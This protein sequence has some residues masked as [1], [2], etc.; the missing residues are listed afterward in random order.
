MSRRAVGTT[1]HQVAE[2]HVPSA[3]VVVGIDHGAATRDEARLEARDPARHR[4]AARGQAAALR[5]VEGVHHV[6]DDQGGLGCHGTDRRRA[7]GNAM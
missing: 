3:E 4:C 6:D 7:R 1:L 5:K 2:I